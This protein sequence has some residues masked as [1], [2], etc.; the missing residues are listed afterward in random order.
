MTAAPI[1]A[2]IIDAIQEVRETF[3]TSTVTTTADG[4]GGVWMVIDP[5]ALG[6]MYG[7]DGTWMAFLITFAYPDAD[8]YPHFVRPDLRRRDGAALGVGFSVAA[9]GPAGEPAVQ[10]SRRSNRLDPTVDT[11]ATKALKVLAWLN[12]Q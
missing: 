5:V 3:A 11:A 10:I 6:P 1:S 12:A 8:V 2:T 9:W 7:Q 4:A